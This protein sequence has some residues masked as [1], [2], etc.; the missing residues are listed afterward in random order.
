MRGGPISSAMQV[1]TRRCSSL[2]VEAAPL[3]Y[4]PVSLLIW[5]FSLLRWRISALSASALT[6]TELRHDPLLQHREMPNVRVPS[7]AVLVPKLLEHPGS[8]AFIHG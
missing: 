7:L 1:Y 5:A 3:A 8:Q 2:T 4:R 6:C